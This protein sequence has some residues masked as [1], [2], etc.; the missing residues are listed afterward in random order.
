MILQSFINLFWVSKFSKC[1]LWI[2]W[3][4]TE[5]QH[6]WHLPLYGK[7]TKP[8][9]SVHQLLHWH[10]PVFLLSH[11][12]KARAWCMESRGIS[13]C[14][15]SWRA[16]KLSNTASGPSAV[17]GCGSTGLYWTTPVQDECAHTWLQGKE[18][19]SR[20]VSI[21]N[22]RSQIQSVIAFVCSHVLGLC[23]EPKCFQNR[24]QST[25]AQRAE[26]D[27]IADT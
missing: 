22:Q 15:E 16:P 11:F 1:W 6:T 26:C 14:P 24:A 4:Q 18:A 8:G 13:A 9:Y 19:N 17:R 23:S 20:V 3:I 21:Q 10:N 2:L 27:S 12:L 25:A 7:H 5:S